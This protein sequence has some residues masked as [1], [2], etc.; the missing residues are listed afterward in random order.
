MEWVRSLAKSRDTSYQLLPS[1]Q[2]QS[3]R[4]TNLN[5]RQSARVALFLF[6]TIWLW[7]F[8]VSPNR[9]HNQ[10]VDVEQ[11]IIVVAHDPPSLNTT[12]PLPFLD[13]PIP[14]PPPPEPEQPQF[15]VVPNGCAL[16]TSEQVAPPPPVNGE[17]RWASPSLPLPL[18]APLSARIATWRAEAPMASRNTWIAFN[19]LACENPSVRRGKIDIAKGEETWAS[20]SEMGIKKIRED[21]IKVLLDAEKGGELEVREEERGRRGIVFTA[22]NADTFERVIVSLRMIRSYGTTLP[23]E[24]WHFPGEEPS[25]GQIFEYNK[26]NCTVREVAGLGKDWVAGRT[27]SFHIKG[28][29]LL[30]SGFEEL[31]YLDSDSIPVRDISPLFESP[32][33]KKYGAIFWPDFWKDQ[34]E[35]A[36]WSIIGVQCRDEWTFET[37]QIVIS[38]ARHLDVLTLVAHMLKSQNWPFFFTLSDG[39]KDL[40]RYAFLALRKRWAVPSRHLESAGWRENDDIT[41][42]RFCGTTMLQYGL[43][44]ESMFVHANLLKRI[45]GVFSQGQAWGR[46]H[47]LTIPPFHLLPPPVNSSLIFSTP[48]VPSNFILQADHLANTNSQGI[49]I[50]LAPPEIRARAI[51]ERGLGTYFHQGHRGNSYV[52]CVESGWVRDD[53]PPDE[54]LF[55]DLGAGPDSE[56]EGEDVYEEGELDDEA[57]RNK[58][59]GGLRRGSSATRSTPSKV[60]KKE[61]EETEC[62]LVERINFEERSEDLWRVVAEVAPGEGDVTEAVGT[63]ELV[64]W[65]LDDALKG[66]EALF[67]KMKGVANGGGFR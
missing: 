11:Q 49:G 13:V 54:S 6:P 67:F 65:D 23:A 38:K 28:A 16:R 7:L 43:N 41:T 26:Y 45:Q 30:Q 53:K 12:D 39:D 22:G 25:S 29:A 40:F 37:G 5:A 44:G 52:L 8:V 64:D 14:L 42:K 55:E 10:P 46:T 56:P 4:W 63:M 57:E 19:K 62:D 35:N 15:P 2:Q 24:V 17:T 51:R 66:F 18:S 27:K 60:E 47:A 33:Y 61:V 9:T 32:A 3:R 58:R 20:L 34:P 36:I 1:A 31:I 48:K 59:G 50:L 21:L